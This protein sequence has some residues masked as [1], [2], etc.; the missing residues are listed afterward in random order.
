MTDL[1]IIKKDGGAYIDSREVAVVIGK[2]HKDLLRDI[3]GYIRIMEKPN[4]RNFAPVDFFLENSYLDTK[5]EARPCYL[6]SRNGCDL[7]AHKLTGER[8]V[9]FT[10]AYVTKFREMETTEREQIESQAVKNAPN[11]GEYNAAARII[12]RALQNMGANSERIVGFLKDLYEPFGISVITDDEFSDVPRMY[13]A[14]QIAKMCGVYSCT[15]NPHSLAVSCILN[16]NILIGEEHKIVTAADYG[17]HISV[18]VRYDEYAVEAVGEWL[19][20]NNY[21]NEIYG[22]DRTYYALYDNNTL[23]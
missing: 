22:F 23:K 21:P 5:G 15:G 7:I 4:G 19:T 6:V 8:G 10:C 18:S 11:L 20:E 2:N 12:V 13:A 16:E 17:N 14:K 1:T 3:R 9:L